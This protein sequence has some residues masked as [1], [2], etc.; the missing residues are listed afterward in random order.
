M[1]DNLHLHAKELHGEMA[2]IFWIILPALVSILITLEIVKNDDR[3]PNVADILKRTVLCI[4]LLLSFN[5]T[6]HV[7]AMASDGITDA[8]GGHEELLEAVK[9]LGPN[10]RGDE[11]HGL[12]DVREHIIYFFSIAA[13]LIAYIGFFAS[14]ALVNFVWAILYVTAPLILPC[15]IPRA[16][17][18]IVSN[19]YRGLISVAVWKVMWTLLGSLLLKLA[20]NPKVVGVEDYFLSMVV[21]LLIGLSMLLIPLF[22]KSLIADGLQSAASGLAAAP[23]L[24][25]AKSVAFALKKHGKKAVGKA[26]EGIQFASRPL[27]NPVT[28]MGRVWANKSKLRQRFHKAKTAYSELGFSKEAKELEIKESFRR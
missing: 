4:L 14:V 18:S 27:T 12:F 24:I 25:A 7:I 26:R 5:F 21:N 11:S 2:H 20:L 1:F 28:G 15:Y 3:G 17:S 16:T 10:K 22:T 6:I 23:G 9:Q 8:I 13:Y 19:L